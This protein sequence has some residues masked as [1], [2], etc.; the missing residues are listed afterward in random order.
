MIPTHFF[1][2]TFFHFFFYYFYA[3]DFQICVHVKIPQDDCDDAGSGLKWTDVVKFGCFVL[4][5]ESNLLV[6]FPAPFFKMFHIWA[7]RHWQDK[8]NVLF[9]F[10][11]LQIVY[12]GKNEI[13]SFQSQNKN[14]QRQPH[15]SLLKLQRYL[16]E[17]KT[18]EKW[19]LTVLFIFFR[20][21]DW[22]IAGASLK[23]DPTNVCFSWV[24][25][26]YL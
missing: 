13:S 1:L 6:L 2:F 26:F 11:Q 7:N 12:T 10:E 8:W 19:K 24:V 25:Y 14:F 20:W 5:T 18:V 3:T 22:G 21:D 17:N 15:H 16:S 4:R 23:R 9:S